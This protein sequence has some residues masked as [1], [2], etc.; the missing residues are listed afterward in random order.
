MNFTLDQLRAFLAVAESGNVGRAAQRLHL[1]QPAATARIKALEDAIGAE[2]FDR[3]DKMALTQHGGALV[4]YAEQF[5]TLTS[6][7]ERDVSS[8]SSTNRLF[9]VGVSET[10]VQ[11]WLP[12]FIQNLREKYPNLSIEIDVDNSLNLRDRL[13]ANAIDLGLMMGP[14]SDFR[15]E[16]VSLP[17]FEMGWFRTPEEP[18]MSLV[19]G[20]PVITFARTTRPHRLVKE[21]VLERYG[22]DVSIFPSS[23]LSACFRMVAMGLGIGALPISP[24]RSYLQSGEIERIT[25]DAS[26]EPLDF[27]ASFRA[28]PESGLERMAANIAHDTAITFD[29]E[30]LLE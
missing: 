5:L 16:N 13:L 8:T 14:V 23:S 3:T 21:Y 12:N 20:A 11:S 6:L 19:K 18:D 1:T 26:P 17:S 9:R 24:A 27:T 22:P 2:L 15:I 7:V 28:T 10:I 29:K 30:N 4:R 25:H